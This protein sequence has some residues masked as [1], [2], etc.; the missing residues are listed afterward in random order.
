MSKSKAD[1]EREEKLIGLLE[2]QK[3]N[4]EIKQ[5]NKE[6]NKEQAKKWVGWMI[7]AGFIGLFFAMAVNA[8]FLLPVFV[9]MIVIGIAVGYFL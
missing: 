8:P 1:K 2:D 5:A 3:R 9:I 6:Y 7:G 4:D